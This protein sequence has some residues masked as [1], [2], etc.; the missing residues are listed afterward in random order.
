MLARQGQ[1]FVARSAKAHDESSQFQVVAD[2]V[3]DIRVVFKNNDVLF[4]RNSRASV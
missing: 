4:Q 2:Q 3:A 1:H